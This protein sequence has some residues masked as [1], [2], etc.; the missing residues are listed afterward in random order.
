MS[1]Y[2]IYVCILCQVY[3]IVC[4]RMSP[5]LCHLCH[6]MSFYLAMLW[7]HITS[8][9]CQILCQLD[10][11]LCHSYLRF[12]R[13]DKGSWIQNCDLSEWRRRKRG[14]RR[15]GGR[16]GER[17]REGEE[18]R[19]RERDIDIHAFLIVIVWSKLFVHCLSKHYKNRA[20]EHLNNCA[21]KL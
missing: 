4:D 20:S 14:E 1:V 3:V 18:V 9:L 10:F 17:G 8:F 2:I 11:N 7:C 6:L 12:S 13:E 19:G 5:S 21:R 15:E 16:E